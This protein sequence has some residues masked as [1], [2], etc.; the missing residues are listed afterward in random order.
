MSAPAEP[1]APLPEIPALSRLLEEA[2]ASG[3][4][5]A[6]AA[7]VLERGRWRHASASG[8]PKESLFDL[9]SLTKPLGTGLACLR[10]LGLGA[11][12][13][14]LPAARLTPSFGRAGKARIT[15][16]QLLEH[17]AGLAAWR[18][19]FAAAL[20][21]PS[22]GA[23]FRGGARPAEAFERAREL[24][25]RALD[26]E[27]PVARPGEE[28]RYGD[29]AFLALGRIVET[30]C[31]EGLPGLF[32]RE[33]QSRL[34]LGDGE[35]RWFDLRAGVPPGL[36]L[37]PTGVERPRPPA[38][39]QEAEL[40]RLPR[41]EVGERPGEV[42]DDHAFSLAGAA[43][44]AGLFGTAAGVARVGQA[45]LEELEGAGRLAA[46]EHARLFALPAAPSPRPLAWDRPSGERPSIGSRLGRG[47]RGAVGHLGFTGTSLWIDLDRGIVVALLTNR[48]RL[49]RGNEGLRELRPRFHDAVAEALGVPPATASA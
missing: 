6:L 26:D 35:L 38:P 39:G 19:L 45:F 14:E 25:F 16:R 24:L 49:G 15:I 22:A 21:D 41:T 34:G 43:G 28:S 42:D 36:P 17:R 27:P 40:A 33:V 18:P 3:V 2:R 10:L 32:A 7:A 9:A 30:L 29:L 31:G 12:D 5:P 44:N 20:R 23:I 48:V 8:T 37:V 46:P 13:L 11:L 4:A 1:P 47:P